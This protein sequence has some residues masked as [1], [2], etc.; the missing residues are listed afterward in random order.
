[1]EVHHH[2]HTERKKWTHYLWEF[3][4][5]FL[6][7]FCGFLAEYQLEH[8][9]EKD[10]EKQ[11]I[12]T[13]VEDLKSDT[14]QLAEIISYEYRREIMVDSLVELLSLSDHKKFGNDIYFYARSLTRPRYFFPNDR[15]LQ[16]LKNSGGLRMIRNLSA[17]DSI[18][19]YDQQ[20]RSLMFVYEDERLIRESFRD[21]TG[22]VF[23]GKVMY[24]MFAPLVFNRPNGNPSLFI[25]DR[26]S[27]NKVISSAQ[28]LKSVIS[29]I[30]LRQENLH[31]IARHLIGF[32]QKEYHLK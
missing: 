7:V 17:S 27:I 19:Y 8:K 16:Q 18:M 12:Q 30:R 28:Y 6:A 11:F 23:D 20:L 24:T 3:L 5:L 26:E 32:L 15:T 31:L 10:R 22:S 25:E 2:P 14:A 1:M 4:M 21:I 9:I 13:M 29:A